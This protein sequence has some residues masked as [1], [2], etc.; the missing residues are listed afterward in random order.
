MTSFFSTLAEVGMYTLAWLVISCCFTFVIAAAF[1]GFPE[2]EEAPKAK[3]ERKCPVTGGPHII[4]VIRKKCKE[5][6][7]DI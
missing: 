1:F 3:K 4:T 5:N 6:Q 7:D 2:D